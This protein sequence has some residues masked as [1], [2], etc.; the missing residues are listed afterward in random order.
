MRQTLAAVL[1]LLATACG[2]QTSNPGGSRVS[3]SV[4]LTQQADRVEVQV[5]PANVTLD[6][7]KS[8]TNTFVGTLTLPVG[9]Q[10]IRATAYFGGSPV[11]EGEVT[12]NVVAGA[13]PAVYLKIYDATGP[14]PTPD[15]G[16]I[17]T[18]IVISKTTP[19]VNESVTF[20][21]TAIDPDGEPL[22]YE[23][24][25]S[26]ASG[27]FGT[28]TQATTTWY[29]DA[30][31]GCDITITVRSNGLSTS[32]FFHLTV[33]A[34]LTGSLPLSV[35]F[36]PNP[37]ITSVALSNGSEW[38]SVSR[39]GPS[40]ASCPGTMYPSQGVTVYVYFNGGEATSQLLDNCGGSAS[41]I[42]S[43]SGVASFQWTAPPFMA[44]PCILTPTVTV[45]PLS[46]SLPVALAI[47]ACMDDTDEPNDDYQHP[48]PLVFS[49]PEEV[50]LRTGLF[51]NDE[52]WY[53]LDTA[54][55]IAAL[56]VTLTT[57]DAIPLEL[58]TSP[59]NA[60]FAA[61]VNKIVAAV[62]PNTSYLLHVLPGAMAAPPTCGSAYD[63][64][65]ER[66]KSSYTCAPAVV[67]SQV[68]TG[69]GQAGAT[70]LKDFIELHNRWGSPVSL[71]NWTI[72][73]S[74]A[75]SSAWTK[76]VTLTGTIA[77]GGYYLVELGAAGSEGV[78]LP[79]PDITHNQNMA[80]LAARVALVSD[81]TTVL[82]GACPSAASLVDFVHYG[83]TNCNETLPPPSPSTSQSLARTGN[84]C[85]WSGDS[86]V[87]FAIQAPT[88]RNSSAPAALCSLL[89]CL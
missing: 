76:W 58:Y 37:R 46:D 4:A 68:Y 45:G 40:G 19:V 10:T 34:P 3:V 61:G 5:T 38:C 35:E 33:S 24:A 55:D 66:F 17:I 30:P 57:A 36:V 84:G 75:T 78:P 50:S 39:T 89:S 29:S 8:G 88:P 51:A 12:V 9:Q 31:A 70:Y 79:T 60:F 7:T 80:L 67:I 69:G 82:S 52:D 1:V 48:T 47:A 14:A 44:Y 20:T 86:Y 27:H 25:Q 53:S 32:T 42:A 6:L 43:A 22:T 77:P 18:S 73:Y 28:P 72:H 59:G 49:I 23:W 26:C 41:L 16:P 64:K 81:D 54:G 15:H 74:S 62:T 65:V 21:A 2:S 56:R 71:D 13:N 85:S 11:G 87:D 83:A 63:L